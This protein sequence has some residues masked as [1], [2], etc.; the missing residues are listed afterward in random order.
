M[1]APRPIRLPTTA[2]DQELA[3]VAAAIQLV[4]TGGARRVTLSGLRR[5]EEIASDALA[6]AQA[7]GVRFALHR[8]RRN[9]PA[10]VV[11]GPA[12]E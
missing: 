2:Y 7:A 11:V 3:D 9:G 4:A 10:T 6:L 8:D 1:D 5:P 12:E